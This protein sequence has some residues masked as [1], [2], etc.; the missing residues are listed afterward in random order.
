VSSVLSVVRKSGFA[1][2]LGQECHICNR[3][4]MF[5]I[6]ENK[7]M[8]HKAICSEVLCSTLLLAG[9]SLPGQLLGQDHQRR[10]HAQMQ[11]LHN[12]PKAYIAML[13]DPERDAY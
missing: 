3:D 7:T 4:R 5:V 2:D 6:R 1:L 13:E 12:D 9:A 8:P 11:R 10:D